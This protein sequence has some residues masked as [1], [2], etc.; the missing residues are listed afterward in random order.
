MRK[1]GC[2]F[3]FFA[4]V[5]SVFASA[6]D[7]CRK[8]RRACEAAGQRPPMRCVR[9]IIGGGEFPGVKVDSADIEACKA[10]KDKK[11]AKKARIEVLETRPSE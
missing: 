7:P 4:F 10:K 1:I 3:L 11:G 2:F 9:T 5:P 8:I 6:A